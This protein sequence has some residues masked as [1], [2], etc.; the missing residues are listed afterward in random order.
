VKTLSRDRA[1]DMASDYEQLDPAETYA[2]RRGITF[3]ARV[4]EIVRSIVPEKVRDRIDGL[5][6]GLRARGD[7]ASNP[8]AVQPPGRESAGMQARL[9]SVAP[10]R[11]VADD[12]QEALR[13]ARTRALVRHARAADAILEAKREGLTPT[14]EQRR[15]L[16]SSRNAFEAVRPN[17][18]QDAEAAYNKDNSL[19]YEAATASPNRAI[20][21]LQLETEIRTG[22]ARRAD[23]FVE[24]WQKLDRTSQRQYE[25]GDM[26]G[27]EATRS[28]MGNMAKGLERDP[29]MES[30]LAN[31]KRELG[32]QMELERRLGLELDFHYGLGI[33]RGRGLG[34]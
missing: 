12:P 29:Q 30:I 27:Y 28:V 4:A 22:P 13:N 7:A 17:G 19:A 8:E 18:W 10:A 25:M 15:E 16:T 1:K 14:V 21:A 32:L 11:E 33:G 6:D 5:L 9:E 24:R 23:R 26:S 3:R 20:R 2:E 34:L 31:R